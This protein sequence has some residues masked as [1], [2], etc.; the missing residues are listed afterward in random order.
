MGTTQDGTNPGRDQTSAHLV[1][2]EFGRVTYECHKAGPYNLNY[3]NLN[4]GNIGKSNLED[5]IMLRKKIYLLSITLFLINGCGS[6][7]SLDEV[8]PDNRTKYQKSRKLP[9]L[10]VP[11]DLTS[12]AL[13]DPLM[14]PDEED[15]NTLSEFQRRKIMREGG[16]LSD[17]EMAMLDN[18]DEKWMVVQGTT[19]EVWPKLREFWVAKGFDMDLDDAE[20]GVLET[21]FK[22]ISVDGVVT[23]REK[24]KIFSEEGGT[25]GKLVLFLSSEIQEKIS[26]SDGQVD[27]IGQESSDEQEKELIDELNLYF[28]GVS[29]SPLVSG[30]SGTGNRKAPEIRA[31]ILSAGEDKEYLTVPDEFSRAWRNIEDVISKSGMYIE[32]KNRE[33]GIYIV[34]YYSSAS[35]E[36]KSF[37]SKLKFW[38]NDDADGKEF[39]ISLTGVGDKTEIVVLDDKDNWSSSD[40]AGRIL[41]LLQSQYNRI[42]R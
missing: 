22:Y 4:Q 14:I 5:L 10:E 29:A 6:F 30:E 35:D 8:L 1:N 36:E 24:F 11:P 16:Q 33:K 7:P 21:Q 28:Y 26:G 19:V 40:D 3:G 34:I 38:E 18:A 20:L 42:L 41:S 27:W 2:R 32:N 15:A 39:H 17:A 25:P 9:D 12:E 31:E 23:H 13:N 37:L